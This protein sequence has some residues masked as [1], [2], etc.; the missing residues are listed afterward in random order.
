M[1]RL[2]N[3]QGD[4]KVTFLGGRR[5]LRGWFFPAATRPNGM[6][7]WCCLQVTFPMFPLPILSSAASNLLLFNY[8][9]FGMSEGAR[10]ARRRCTLDGEV[11][12]AISLAAKRGDRLR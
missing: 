10:R 3:A 6:S 12:H 2:A 7:G 5:R 11:V 9:G 1:L 4:E 8:R